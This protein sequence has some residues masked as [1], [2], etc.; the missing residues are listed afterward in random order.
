MVERLI[1]PFITDQF[2]YV[3]LFATSSGLHSV[4]SDKNNN[5]P[6]QELMAK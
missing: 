1:D 2:I 4:D 5:K 3:Y 6:H